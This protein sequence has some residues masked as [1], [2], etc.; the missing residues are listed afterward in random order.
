MI[1][2]LGSPIHVSQSRITNQES[3]IK[4]QES[5]MS[6]LIVEGLGKRYFIPAKRPTTEPRRAINLGFAR[7]PLPSLR[8]PGAPVQGR[9]LW[10]LR[11]VSFEIARGT[12]LGI[13][14]ANGA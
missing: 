2:D 13:V 10:A 3:R 9:D 6:S 14:G 4:N 1:H 11:H 7:V 5:R 12:I 8:F